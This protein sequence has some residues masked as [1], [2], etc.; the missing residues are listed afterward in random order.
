LSAS[1]IIIVLAG[2]LYLHSWFLVGTIVLLSLVVQYEMIKAFK[3][4]GVKLVE[5]ILY[6]FALLTMP[7]YYFYGLQAVFVLQMFAVCLIFVAAIL[8]RKRL[9][10]DSIMASVFNLYYP[11]MFFVFFYMILFVKDANGVWDIELS[12]LMILIA[13]GCSVMTDTVAYFVGSF[14]GKTPLCPEISPKKTVEGALGG[15]AGGIVGVQV[16]A[17]L[18]DNGRVHL[19]EYLVFSFLLSVLAQIG[20]LAASLLKRKLGIKDY[21]NTIPGHGGFM[22]RIDSTLFILPIVYLFYHL[23]LGLG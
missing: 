6:G 13:I 19:V 17:I 12:R 1:I 11:Q 22:D 5:P 20:D 14:F 21:G 15:L 2:L 8:F 7:T 16:I 18:F 4:V 23:Y 3:N 10:F 9:N